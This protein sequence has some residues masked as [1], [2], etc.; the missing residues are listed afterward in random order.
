MMVIKPGIFIIF[1]VLILLLFAAIAVLVLFIKLCIKKPWAAA[2]LALIVLFLLG[3]VY[4]G[5]SHPRVFIHQ[6][7]L[8]LETVSPR[9]EDATTAIW[10]PGIEDQFK[11]DVYPSKV[12]AV[13]SVGL[14][15]VKPVRHVFG[16]QA[17]PTGFILFQG[18]HERDLIEEFGRAIVKVFPEIN[19]RIKPETAAVQD[20]EV[21]IRLDLVNIQT[22]SATWQSESENRGTSGTIRATV[23]AADRQTSID[24]DFVEKPWVDN[25]SGFM[26]NKPISRFIIAKSAESCITEA[27]ANRQ[28][29]ENARNQVAEMLGQTSRRLSR[30]SALFSQVNSNDILE[31]GFVL[32]RFV[33]S[34]E[35]TAGKIW[36]QALLID[37]S[38]EK[39]TQLARR[40]ANMARSKKMRWTGMF[41]SVFGLLMLI[42][43]VYLF[44]N[45]ATKGYY[46]WSLR[47]AGVVL[48]IIVIFLLLA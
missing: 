31:G 33:Q 37:A 7:E 32:D 28:A 4:L 29:M 3:F 9:I 24:A 14:R 35:G 20:N 15:I 42:T 44:L 1:P 26:N 43:V 30:A 41:F 38:A 5:A 18:A 17:L 2:I 36:R 47:I 46:A 48:A 6:D 39:L 45:A 12:S 27:E 22:Q 34:F 11:A 16:D 21:G 10:S 13:R 40:K 23:L 8:S 25:F 19:W